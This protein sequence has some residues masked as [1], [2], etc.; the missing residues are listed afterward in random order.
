MSHRNA[1]V[2]A[3]A[4][5][6]FSASQVAPQP[7]PAPTPTTAASAT[8][9]AVHTAQIAPTPLPADVISL[10]AN[11]KP[12]LSP[13]ARSWVE[14][15][16]KAIAH[17]GLA[18][19]AALATARRSVTQQFAGQSMTSSDIDHLVF[20]VMIEATK[21]AD[22]DLRA[23]MAEAKRANN[24]SGAEPPAPIDLNALAAHGID[25]ANADPLSVELRKRQLSKAARRGFDVAMA[26]AE[27]HTA[28][29]PGKQRI[30]A[31]LS[32]AEQVG[33]DA[34]LTFS[35][36]RNRNAELAAKGSAIAEADS[37]TAE[38][39]DAVSDPQYW[40]GF[41]IAT[42]IFGD[43]ALGARGNT[44]TGPGSLRIRDALSAPAQAGFNA[45][46]TFHLA[47]NYTR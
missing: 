28:P 45:A 8:N 22:E 46:V 11:V 1:R 47:H 30:R 39:R 23:L 9:T 10:E 38:A 27:G 12:M 16:G 44:A 6:L 32:P 3:I 15:E 26:A 29:G 19:G 34:G 17:S 25:V 7:L 4:A 18:P 5:A 13:S 42:G 20:L 35:L 43:P 33:F 31:A 24:A 14:S 40:L 21:S 36:D 41:D 2:A 37:A